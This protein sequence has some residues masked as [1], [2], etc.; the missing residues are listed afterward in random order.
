MGDATCFSGC[1]K[2]SILASAVNGRI[3]ACLSY[4][5]NGKKKLI[6]AILTR[7]GANVVGVEIVPRRNAQPL[8]LEIGQQISVL[9]RHTYSKMFFDCNLL[10]FD[11]DALSSK[12]QKIILSIPNVIKMVERR[13]HFRVNVPASMDVKVEMKYDKKDNENSNRSDIIYHGRL[14]N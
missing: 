6:K 14:P 3:S 5:C 8:S 7:L 9:F 1:E 2:R 11:T 4:H 13:R 10:G 12:P